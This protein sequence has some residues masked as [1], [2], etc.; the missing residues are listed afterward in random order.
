M[1]E[2]NKCQ[3]KPSIPRYLSHEY[4]VRISR[5]EKRR[6]MEKAVC[7][8]LPKEDYMGQDKSY[9][10]L[11]MSLRYPIEESVY[12]DMRFIIRSD[13]HHFLDPF[14]E[15]VAV[16]NALSYGGNCTYG[17]LMEGI[18]EIRKSIG[19]F[20]SCQESIRQSLYDTYE[21]R[22]FSS[23]EE[24][25]QIIME[26]EKKAFPESRDGFVNIVLGPRYAVLE[27]LLFP[28]ISENEKKHFE[29]RAL[30]M[31]EKGLMEKF[32]GACEIE[33]E[34]AYGFLSHDEKFEIA[35]KIA[36]RL[37][38][39]YLPPGEYEKTKKIFFDVLDHYFYVLWSREAEQ[40][41]HQSCLAYSMH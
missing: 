4:C 35:K 10:E 41:F 9:D 39:K 29:E 31:V 33:P 6:Y 15:L 32:H 7:A 3:Y 14:I 36:P 17:I 13:Q 40:N 34:E 11:A 23:S 28:I 5:P 27:N 19:D 37:F 16:E 26:A 20:I 2:D 8:K 12:S 21:E 18:V 22:V 24:A 25:N 1:K 38:V 30:S